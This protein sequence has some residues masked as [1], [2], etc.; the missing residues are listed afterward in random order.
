MSHIRT[1]PS[2]WDEFI[3][4]GDT[5]TNYTSSSGK[6][7]RSTGSAIEFTADVLQLSGGTMTGFYHPTR[8]PNAGQCMLLPSSM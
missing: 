6:F 5:P 2:A 1:V 3:K 8:R 4:L 7:L